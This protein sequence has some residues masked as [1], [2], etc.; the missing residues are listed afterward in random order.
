MHV[1]Y[2]F[3]VYRQC[4]HVLSLLVLLRY[5]GKSR[6]LF[7]FNLQKYVLSLLVLLRYY[8]KSRNLF[9]F[10]LQKYGPSRF[11]EKLEE[12]S[13]LGLDYSARIHICRTRPQRDHSALLHVSHVTIT[14]LIIP[15]SSCSCFY[16]ATTTWS[17]RV[18]ATT[19]WWSFLVASRLMQPF[20]V[21]IPRC[22]ALD[23]VPGYGKV[24]VHLH[25]IVWR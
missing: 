7:W 5:Y 4:E 24:H 3:Q 8:G 11:M 21:I 15:R 14:C 9:W 12:S 25:D 6:N 18:G 2:N 17:F 13:N 19:T 10:N 16:H 1:I 20:N 22:F 23:T